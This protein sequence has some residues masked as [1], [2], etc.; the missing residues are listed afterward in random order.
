MLAEVE[1][2]QTAADEARITCRVIWKYRAA[3]RIFRVPSIPAQQLVF[4]ALL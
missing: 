2:P 1:K 3:T 4:D